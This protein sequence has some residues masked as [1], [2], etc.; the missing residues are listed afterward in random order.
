MKKDYIHNKKNFLE[1][2]RELRNNPTSQEGILWSRLRRKQCG[3]KFQRQHSIDR[4][5][6][7][8]Y[9]FEKKLIIEIDGNQHVDNEAYDQMRT[10]HLENLGYR[11][12]RCTNT[13]ITNN[14]EGVLIKIFN[15]LETHNTP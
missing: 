10:N 6:V 15:I 2:R 3:V 7:D 5:I 11:V 12:I 9:C 4:Y 14:L 1:L 13:D 8:F